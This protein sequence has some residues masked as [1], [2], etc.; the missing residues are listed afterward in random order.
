MQAYFRS[1]WSG[2]RASWAMLAVELTPTVFFG[3]KIPRVVFQA[4]FFVLIAK[5][6]GGNEMA[7]FALIGNAV[8]AAV[9][10]AI[11]SFAIVIEI[12]K[13]AGTLPLLVAS[14]MHWLPAMVGRSAATFGNAVFN[15][16]IVLAL[17]IPFIA[18]D[19]ALINLLRAVPVFLITLIATAGL[20]W[21]VGAIALPMRWGTLISNM[22][23]YAM[24]I[25]CGV[26]FPFTAL[27]PAG[28]WIGRALPMT[29]G[30]LAIRAVIDGAPY[31]Q[32][33][34][35]MG[36]EMLIGLIY[37][38]VAWMMFGYRLKAARQNGNL[39]LV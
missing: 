7:R 22:T 8:H 28:Q 20:G 30:L 25:T 11:I 3:A 6:A 37:G 29:H 39:E 1:F 13:W 5:A 10:P 17:L 21:L 27:P 9:F 24:M 23:G 32:V 15:T 35:L 33:A 16:V 34:G 18:P 19:I 38:V 26:N 2:V 12:E 36:T 14:P 4:L 31:S